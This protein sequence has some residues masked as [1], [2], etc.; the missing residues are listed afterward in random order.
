MFEN[1]RTFET[2]YGRQDLSL[3]KTGKDLRTC[4]RL[5]LG[6]ITRD[7]CKANVQ[8]PRSP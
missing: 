2:T 8:L 6:K 3:L 5:M 1:A 4:K 7:R